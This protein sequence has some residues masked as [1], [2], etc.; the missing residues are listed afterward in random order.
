MQAAASLMGRVRTDEEMEE[1]LRTLM[2]DGARTE[3][4]LKTFIVE[5]DGACRPRGRDGVEWEVCPT[6]LDGVSSVSRRGAGA[7]ACELVLDQRQGRFCMAHTAAADGEACDTVSLLA[8]ATGMSRAWV[9]PEVLERLAGEKGNGATVPGSVHVKR[10]DA[11][12]HSEAVVSCNGEITHAHGGSVG[13]HLQIAREVREAYALMC[14]NAERLRLGAADTPDG[15]QID[16]QTID[17]TFS[18]EIDDVSGLID[19][20]FDG[21]PPLMMRGNK[22][23]V[24]GDQYHVPA[25][26]MEEMHYMGI[27]ISPR[28]LSVGLHHGCPASGVLRLLAC[29][30]LHY[31]R[32]LTCNQV[33]AGVCGA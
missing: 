20:M 13:A 25:A 11:M 29:L 12:G 32:M 15:P 19:K 7:P 28:F 33:T 17:M 22:I 4:R 23:H 10:E 27:D 16:L 9:C 18:Q 26:N 6:G 21:K 3:R 5:L 14:E 2:L 8:R 24:E 1:A 31:D 30:Q